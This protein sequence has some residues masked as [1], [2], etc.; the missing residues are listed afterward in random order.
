MKGIIHA[1]GT[2]YVVDADL[3]NNTKMLKCG[4]DMVEAAAG[5]QFAAKKVSI[6]P[7]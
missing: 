4:R 3:I 2:Q 5:R 1:V 7:R 6:W